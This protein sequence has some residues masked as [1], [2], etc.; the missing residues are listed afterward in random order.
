MDRIHIFINGDRGLA[1]LEGLV[2][3]GQGIACVHVPAT[4]DPKGAVA[5]RI[6]ALGLAAEPVAD[7]N[8]PDFVRRYAARKPRL[9]IIAGYSTIFRAPIFEAPEL[10]TINCH[11]G[12]VPAYRGGS[13]LNWQILNGEKSAGI[14][15][16]RVDAGIDSG[17]VLALAELAIAPDDTIADLHGRANT[18]FPE[19]VVATV[20]RFAHGDISG[21][22]QDPA[23]ATYWHQ[24]N[25]ADGRIAWG[26]QSAAQVHDTVR[27]LGA[28]YPGAWTQW[29]EAKLRILA[30]TLDCPN[31]RG[32]PGRIVHVSG[33]GPL[34]VCADRAIRLVA[35]RLGDGSVP[36]LRT[37][38]RCQ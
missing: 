21:R 16:L 25:D 1:V 23:Q 34:V 18:A 38:E 30:A 17:D 13:P 22:A 27:A 28:P 24:R 7:V 3:D 4:L 26:V 36:K 29:G 32:V 11:A 35:W 33:C 19:L 20:R 8:D 15:V 5:A 14:S 37:G 2:R 9:G 6:A 10:G 12:R 31:V